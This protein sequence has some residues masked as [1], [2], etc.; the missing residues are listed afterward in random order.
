MKRIHWIT[1]EGTEGSGKSTLIELVK[2]ALEERGEKVLLTREPGGVS[3]SEEIR[4][5][6]LDD[7]NKAMDGLT[8]ALLFAA[9][10]RQHLVEKVIPALEQGMTVLMDRFVDSSIAYQGYGRGVGVKEVIAINELAIEGNLPEVT[11]L[12]DLDPEQGLERVRKNER[13]VNR[14]D[15][16]KISFYQSVRRGYLEI[17]KDSERIVVLDATRTPEE[18]LEDVLR[19]LSIKE[20]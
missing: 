3:I 1:F 13:A 18:L 8:E 15:Q 16:E 17:A 6:I 19:D 20:K 4:Q 7:K 10:R 11:Y 12:L 5:I 2:K 14:M 9:A